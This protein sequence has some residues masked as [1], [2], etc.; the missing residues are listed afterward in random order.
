MKSLSSVTNE[1]VLEGVKGVIA[2]HRDHQERVDSARMLCVHLADTGGFSDDLNAAREEARAV[3][4]SV[5]GDGQLALWAPDAAAAIVA[6]EPDN[7]DEL[8]ILWEVFAYSSADLPVK[9]GLPSS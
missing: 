6:M 4:T 8:V 5:A 9:F 7:L 3:A 1:D 2:R